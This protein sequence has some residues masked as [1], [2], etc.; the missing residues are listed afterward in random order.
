MQEEVSKIKDIL[1]IRFAKHLCSSSTVTIGLLASS[2]INALIFQPG[3]LGWWSSLCK[4]LLYFYPFAD[5]GIKS[6]L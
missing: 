6:D 1:G 4:F 3:S 2:M 5:D